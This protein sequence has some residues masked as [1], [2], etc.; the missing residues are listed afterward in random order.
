MPGTI[1]IA[2]IVADSA[3][4]TGLKW[5]A[6]ASGGGMTLLS[7]TTLSGSETSISITP[8]G[9]I[10]LCI[11]I[12]DWQ[13]S[14]NGTL[15]VRFN[16]LNTDV[17]YVGWGG[18]TRGYN[19]ENAATPLSADALYISQQT[20]VSGNKTNS[21]FLNVYNAANTNSWKLVDYTISGAGTTSD[22]YAITQMGSFSVATASAISSFQFITTS[23]F[24]GGTVKIYGVK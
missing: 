5:A 7:T 1:P 10:N 15:R 8:T 23:T 9:Y 21:G 6:P 20:F 16:S 17:N 22:D 13:L 24:N 2:S 11:L 18:Y 4:A 3:E 19:F 14:S 12:E